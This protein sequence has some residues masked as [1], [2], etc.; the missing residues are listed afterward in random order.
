MRQE[1]IAYPEDGYDAC[2]AVEDRSFWFAHRNRA[3]DALLSRWPAPGRFADVGG[4][5]GA[6]AAYL[7]MRGRDVVVVEPGAPG[8]ANARTRGVTHVIQSTLGQ[9]LESGTIA[10][11]SLG[12]VGAFDVLEHIADAAAFLADARGALAPGGRLYLSVP[13]F[14]ALWSQ[15]DDEAEHV[16]RYTRRTLARSVADAGFQV[17]FTSYLFAFLMPAVA[18]LRALPY[19]LGLRRRSS[20]AT[21]SDDHSAPPFVS[22][23]LVREIDMLARGKSVP[24]GGSVI[25]VAT[26]RA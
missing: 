23:L 15:A 9:A 11:A 3:I 22:R 18:I 5:N 20:L 2:F 13:A 1:N 16:R 25:L 26:Q 12:G 6:V 17:E 8:C 24:F 7:Q 21:A 10:A 4:G 19:R 14:N